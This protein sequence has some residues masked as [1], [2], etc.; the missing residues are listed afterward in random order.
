M[1][2]TKHKW[3]REQTYFNILNL[4]AVLYIYF[5]G[6][7]LASWSYNSRL[8]MNFAG[9]YDGKMQTAFLELTCISF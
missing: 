1:N 8:G 9:A 2:F 5:V 7:V 4:Y 3:G 6:D